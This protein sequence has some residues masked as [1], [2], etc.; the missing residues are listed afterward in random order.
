M[1]QDF[2][3]QRENYKLVEKL[4]AAEAKD[5]LSLLKSLVADIVEEGSFKIIGGRVWELSPENHSYILRYQYGN[6]NKIPENYQ[7]QISEQPVLTQVTKRRV[8]LSEETDVLLQEKGIRLYSVIGAGDIVTVDKD[9]LFKYVIGFNA[10]EILQSFYEIL[11]IISSVA[12]AALRN[13]KS[14]V[15]SEKFRRDLVN[16]SEIQKNLLPD[17]HIKFH[18]YDIFGV[19]LPDDQVGGDYF[20]Y[21]KNPYNEDTLGIVISDAASKGL[22]AAIQ[23]LFVSGAIRMGMSYSLRISD[24]IGR[25]NSLI[26]ETFLYEHFVTL[27]YCELSLSSNRLVLYANAGHCAPIHYHP[28]IDEFKSLG[29]TGG[30]LGIMPVQKYGVENIRMRHGDILLLFTDGI[31]EA[32]NAGKELYGEERL[33]EL[34]KKNQDLSAKEICYSIIEDVQKFTSDSSYTD[35]RTIVVVKRDKKSD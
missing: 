23:S 19:C 3:N 12:T 33:K 31:S 32:M 20:D 16:A 35:D 11:S 21:L 15:E 34:I 26:F 13:M 22:P 25:M 18:D 14:R 4:I 30:L 27:F 6:L 2:Q 28:G 8:L 17:H 10:P 5:E 7:I 29:P 24:L 1:Y 9:K